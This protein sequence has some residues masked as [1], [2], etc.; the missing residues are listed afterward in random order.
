MLFIEDV[1]EERSVM[2]VSIDESEVG[3]VLEEPV[4]QRMCI[5]WQSLSL[6]SGGQRYTHKKG[7]KDENTRI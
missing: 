2:W 4:E 3:R 7:A 5:F 6:G 1:L